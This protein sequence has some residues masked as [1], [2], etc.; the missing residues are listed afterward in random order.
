MDKNNNIQRELTE[1][2]KKNPVSSG[3]VEW[4]DPLDKPKSQQEQPTGKLGLASLLLG[5]AGICMACAPPAAAILGAAGLVCGILSL[6]RHE[7]AKILG[8]IGILLSSGALI[9]G[10][11]ISVMRLIVQSGSIGTIDYYNNFANNAGK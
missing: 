8:V 4:H 3:A 1:E 10:L 11:I 2:E 7:S 5:I 9:A 6:T